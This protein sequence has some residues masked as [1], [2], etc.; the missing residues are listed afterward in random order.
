MTLREVTAGTEIEVFRGQG[1]GELTL[2]RGDRGTE[3]R[4]PLHDGSEARWELV[5]GASAP[6][7]EGELILEFFGG[8][9]GLD[10]D[11]IRLRAPRR[12]A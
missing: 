10:V 7:G 12:A 2:R 8:P 11:A 4:L 1:S 3:V 9:S 6:P 5:P